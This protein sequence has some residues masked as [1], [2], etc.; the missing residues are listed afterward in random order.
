MLEVLKFYIKC[1]IDFISMLFTID[2]G[3]T[4]LGMV[5]CICFIFFPTVIVFV[6]II[7]VVVLDELDDRYDFYKPTESWTS[8]ERVTLNY[9]DGH[10]FTT[11]HNRSRR[12]RYKL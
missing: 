8:S 3:F 1:I 11:Y 2:V 10:T 9:G 6:R 4:S 7:K 12:R 5:M